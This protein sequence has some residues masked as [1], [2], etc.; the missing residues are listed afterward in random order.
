[1]V[2]ISGNARKALKK[3][4]GRVYKTIRTIGKLS[5]AHRIIS[6]GDVCT[7]A[8]LDAGIKPHLAVFDFR[9]MRKKLKRQ[10]ITRLRTQYPEP[11]IY[12]NP[13]GT[14]SDKLVLDAGSLLDRGGAI[15]IEGEEDLTALAFIKAA[16]KRDV[17]V[18]GQPGEGIV[19]VKADERIKK[20]IERFL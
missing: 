13:P 4:L 2:K 5:K 15:L 8:L 18:Y 1:M 12:S 9:Y 14:L 17:I 11:L 16:G 6:V 19:L 3:P 7:L 10:D 20:K